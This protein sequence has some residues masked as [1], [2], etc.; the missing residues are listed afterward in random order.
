MHTLTPYALMAE[1]VTALEQLITAL[2]EGKDLPEILKAV[3]G[4][5]RVAWHLQNATAAVN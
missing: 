2:D 1:L 5:G 3:A 4:V